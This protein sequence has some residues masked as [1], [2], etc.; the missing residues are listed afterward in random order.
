MPELPEVETVCRSLRQ[1]VLDT[2]IK[3]VQ[4]Y[5]PRLIQQLEVD[6]FTQRL[7]GDRFSGVRRRG[8]YILLD[9]DS[10]QTL[11]VHLRMTGKLLYLAGD[12][13]R[14]KH[15]HVVFTF[16]DCNTLCYN[17]VRQFG[18]LQLVP[19]V[20][21]LELSGLRTLGPEPLGTDFTEA[22]L[23]AQMQ[24]KKQKA[25]AFLLDQRNIAGI[26]NIYAD[27]ILFQARIHPEEPVCNLTNAETVT[28]LWTA[29]RDRL[30]QGIQYGGSSI[31]DYVD[32]FGN[33]GSFQKLHKAYGHSGQPCVECGCTMEKIV[34]AGRSSCYCPNCQAKRK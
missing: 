23:C 13:P 4:V 22:W 25:K 16:T 7:S 2:Q 20:S 19:T 24:G 10:G 9:L 8:K 18:T 14:E 34:S 1:T 30:E 29:I 28:V 15:T 11:V 21:C 33:V 12:V 32:S 27:E 5:L 26:G 3:E 17:D 31:K 6:D